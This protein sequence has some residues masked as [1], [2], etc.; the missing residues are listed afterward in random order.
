MK[1][2]SFHTYFETDSV[3]ACTYIKGK[4]VRIDKKLADGGALFF[5]CKQKWQVIPQDYY[6]TS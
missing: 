6:L 2:H 4:Q 3:F 1:I 5:V